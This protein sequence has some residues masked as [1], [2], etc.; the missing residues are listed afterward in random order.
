MGASGV[1]SHTLCRALQELGPLGPLGDALHWIL[2]V[3]VD[4]VLKSS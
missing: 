2:E 4:S 1:V 3:M